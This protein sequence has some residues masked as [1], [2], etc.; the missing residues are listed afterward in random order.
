LCG[1]RI[2]PF[3]GVLVGVTVV[4]RPGFAGE[5]VLVNGDRITGTIVS[6]ANR[7]MVVKVEDAGELT[8]DVAKLK[9]FSANEV[10]RIRLGDGAAFEARIGAGPDGTVEIRKTAG[11]APQV[12]AIRDLVAI[13]PPSPAWTGEAMLNG[14][15]TRG[16]SRTTEAGLAFELDKKWTRD[17]LRFA[18]EYMYGRER[19]SETGVTSTTDDFG[20]VYGKYSHDI[21]GAVY[22]EGNAKLLHDLLA[23]LQYRFSP[24]AG[25]GYRWFDGPGLELF[26]DVGIAYTDKRFETF[27]GQS[28][29]GPQFEYGVEWKPVNRLRLSNT[30]EYYPSFSDFAGN[31]M[32]DTQAAIHVT[33]WRHSFIELRGEYHHDTEP[34]PSAKQ[35][36]YRF[37][38]GPGL[39]F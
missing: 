12:V 23:E 18:G 6:L 37:I 30:L 8:I 5:V 9:T 26:T 34:A 31:Y 39:D 17:R 3:L 38:L 32:L 24:A 25:I 36:E 27:G 33:L 1:L 2:A 22:V 4:A 28:F 15:I 13:N 29:W 10:L 20:N 21:H 11:G 19:S 7:E 35:A 16:D 14:K